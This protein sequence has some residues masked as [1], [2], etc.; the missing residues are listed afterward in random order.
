[1]LRDLSLRGSLACFR[2][3]PAELGR[4]APA[5]LGLRLPDG[6]R[7]LGRPGERVSEGDADVGKA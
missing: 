2:K 6:K 1:M 3:S 4:M 5:E 7:G